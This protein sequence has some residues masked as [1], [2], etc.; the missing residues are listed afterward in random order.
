MLSAEQ[1]DRSDRDWQ[2]EAN[3]AISSPA[4]A[5]LLPKPILAVNIPAEVRVPLIHFRV[6]VRLPV[7]EM[8]L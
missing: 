1:S 5:G 8:S 6:A 4:L 3:A 7:K 2:N